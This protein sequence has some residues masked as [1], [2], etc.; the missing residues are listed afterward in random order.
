MKRTLPIAL[1]ALMAGCVAPVEPADIA[2]ASYP[3]AFLTEALVGDELR[4][5]D[6]SAGALHDFEPSVRDLDQLRQT[7]HLILWDEALESWAHRAEESLGG[8]APAVIEISRLPAGEDYLE[9]EDDGHG[10]GAR[11]PHTWNDPLAMQASLR[12]LADELAAAYPEL[13]SAIDA[14]A[15]A[16]SARLDALHADMADGL[17]GCSRTTIITNHEAYNYLA[18]RYG[19]DIFA[20][21]GLEPGSEPS[22]ATVDEAIRIIKEQGIPVIFIEEGADK[23]NLRAIKAETG[24]EVR[25]LVTS[26]SRPPAGDHIDS[27]YRNLWEL[28]NALGCP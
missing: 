9:G 3:A 23:D 20:L 17:T 15:G 26:E 24:V 4:I 12:F 1:L 7:T 25:V 16:L 8:S 10:H 28:R 2:V 22:P 11:D 14:R 19:F 18:H 21:H 13:A 5:V 27:Q 6:L